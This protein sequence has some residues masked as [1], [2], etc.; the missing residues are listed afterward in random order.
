MQ[1]L[2]AHLCQ[3]VHHQVHHFVSATEM[4]VERDGHAVFEAAAE[5]GFLQRAKL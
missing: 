5:D 2:E 4:M 1:V 3:F